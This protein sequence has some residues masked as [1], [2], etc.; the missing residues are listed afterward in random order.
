[1]RTQFVYDDMTNYNWNYLDQYISRDPD[2]LNLIDVCNRLFS[3][4]L[5]FTFLF[6]FLLFCS[7][8]Y[9]SGSFC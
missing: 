8:M 2:C 3:S 1:M 5:Y 6:C 9:S 4:F 7:M